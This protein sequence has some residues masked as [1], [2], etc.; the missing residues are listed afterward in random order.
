MVRKAQIINAA[1]LLP[2]RYQQHITSQLQSIIQID[3]SNFLI[4]C[5]DKNK[6]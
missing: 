1:L 4:L 2:N 6:L 5:K 3:T